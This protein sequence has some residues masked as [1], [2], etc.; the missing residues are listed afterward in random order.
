MYLPL[1]STITASFGT[2]TLEPAATIFP[3]L[4]I[5]MAFCK[6]VCGSFTIVASVKAKQSFRR[7]ETPFTG[8]VS[9]AAAIVQIIQH[10]N[11]NRRYFIEKVIDKKIKSNRFNF[12]DDA[13]ICE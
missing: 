4:M 11:N 8:N 13:K 2:V 12:Y 10:S 1:Q 6:M 7:S 3:C 9:C 5:S